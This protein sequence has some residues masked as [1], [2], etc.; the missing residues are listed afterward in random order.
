MQLWKGMG[1]NVS[2]NFIKDYLVAKMYLKVHGK[3]KDWKWI[4]NLKSESS[5]FF[6]SSF[7]AASYAALIFPLFLVPFDVTKTKAFCEIGPSTNSFYTSIVK[8]FQNVMLRDGVNGLWRGTGLSCFYSIAHSVS[9]LTSSHF[10]STAPS[11]DF[12]Q[13]FILNT[14]VSTFLY[15]ID[16]IMF[17]K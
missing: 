2:R 10:L 17:P 6:V 4:R 8:S 11:F 5:R 13:F 9:L 1:L 7:F 3:I 14:I 12:Q 15:P 16:T